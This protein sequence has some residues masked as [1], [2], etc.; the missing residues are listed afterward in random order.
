M[1]LDVQ[2][3]LKNGIDVV[4]DVRNFY[5]LAN[6]RHKICLIEPEF[7]FFTAFLSIGLQNHFKSSGIN[8]FYE[9]PATYEVL[10]K[11]LLGGGND[12]NSE[13]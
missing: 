11:L 4:K 13:S 2:M 12:L 6:K 8:H 10:R 5:K 7:I 3:P 1:L 9:K